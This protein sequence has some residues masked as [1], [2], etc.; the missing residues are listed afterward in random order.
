[1]ISCI[2]DD[3]SDSLAAAES[4]SPARA[5]PAETAAHTISVVAMAPDVVDKVFVAVAALEVFAFNS[6]VSQCFSN[7]PC[8]ISSTVR[9]RI[10]EHG[11]K[12]G[13]GITARTRGGAVGGNAALHPSKPQSNAPIAHR[14]VRR[15]CW[16]AGLRTHEGM[17][18]AGESPS[19]VF[20]GRSGLEIRHNSF[21]VA[22]AV[23]G[24]I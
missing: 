2:A 17:Y 10:N 9:S 1:V 11:E 6:M 8:R 4:E 14:D 16:Q 13:K 7:H 23:P 19:R 15:S 24:L 12:D 5:R 3:E 22:G 18:H 20:S 21:T